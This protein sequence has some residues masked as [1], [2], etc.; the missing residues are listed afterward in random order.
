MN[1]DLDSWYK[2]IPT[3]RNQTARTLDSFK[4]NE[5]FEDDYFVACVDSLIDENK[6]V[7]IISN[8]NSE[9]NNE[10]YKKKKERADILYPINEWKRISDLYNDYDLFPPELHCDNFEQG[11]IGDCYFID[12]VALI[13]NYGLLT[14]LFPIKEKNPYGYY[15]VILFIN[16]WK[17]VIVDDYIPIKDGRPLGCTSKK[18]QKCFYFMLL[19]KA[20]AKVNKN[21]YNIYGGLSKNSLLVLTGFNAIFKNFINADINKIIEDIENGIRKQGYFY[22]ID[23]ENHAYS[24]LDIETYL[25]N[26]I[27]Y[28][29][30]KVRNPWGVTG[31][32]FLKKK[33]NDD[34]FNRLCDKFRNRRDIVEDE[35]VPRLGQIN[36][37]NDNGIFYI[38]KT[39]LFTFFE[40]YN[41]CYNMFGSSTIEFLL[42]I[43][44]ENLNRRYF[45]FELNATEE[46]LVQLNLTKYFF[47]DDGKMEFNSTKAYQYN[48]EMKPRYPNNDLNEN[49][50]KKLPKGKYLIEWHYTSNHVPEEILFWVHYIGNI[51]LDFKGMSQQSQIRN[52]F[53]CFNSNEVLIKEK[54]N[55]KLSEKLGESFYRK[56]K[57]IEFTQEYLGCNITADQEDRGYSLTYQENDDIAFSFIMN[58]EDIKNSKKLS[59][60]LDFPEYIFEGNQA[61][62]RRI[63]GEG[64]IYEINKKNNEEN[65]KLVF[66]GHINYNLFPQK[67][68]ENDQSDLIVRVLSR[69]F[70]LSQEIKEDELVCCSLMRREGYGDL[71]GRTKLDKIHPHALVKCITPN[72]LGWRCDRC[73]KSF[74]NREYSLYCTL[75]DFDYCNDNCTH[76]CCRDMTPHFSK[77]FQFK[78]L[79]HEHPLVKVKIHE[80]NNHL[81]CFSCL[82]QIPKEKRLYYCTKCDFRLCEKCQIAESRGRPWQFTTSWHEHPLT[83]CK[84]KGKKFTPFP[85]ID[86]DKD[87]IDILDDYAFYFQCN[88][89]GIE[90]SRK[91]DSFYCTACDFYICMKCY[92]N[93]YFYNGR[94]IENK[95]KVN[96]KNEK[97]FPVYCRCYLDNDNNLQIVNCNKCNRELNLNDWTYYCS[98][99]NS[100]F[101]RGC[102]QF[103]QV[104]F[105]NNI[106]IY[107]GSIDGNNLKNGYGITYK[108]NN[109][110]N[111][112]GNWDNGA[113]KLLRNINHFSDYS[114]IR[115][116][117]NEDI[118]CDICY[119]IC[120]SY[121]SGL[122]CRKNNLDIC[123]TCII[124]INS[125]LFKPLFNGY[126]VNIIR[127]SDFKKCDYCN[128]KKR[129][130]FFRIRKNNSNSKAY[131]LLCF[132]CFEVI[133]EIKNL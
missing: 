33:D 5:K 117:F 72:R 67:I 38:S 27:I 79:Q 19:E 7:Q 40:S 124:K 118:Q 8:F 6:Y 92:K 105:E 83:F 77:G 42:K 80:R 131:N 56:A 59:Q 46:S 107:D 76:K 98:N 87:I 86:E 1:K 10:D 78:T 73:D 95:V 112:S 66:T 82:K 53:H 91:K 2:S 17:R 104:I 68:Q 23:D 114:L 60:N 15:E 123:D 62:N 130:I 127:F 13:S 57:I 89:C 133:K 115:N 44:V 75:C 37:T 26:N 39:Y 120:D 34:Y 29:V 51:E 125:R 41:K 14:R 64:K 12:M 22:G 31:N 74:D 93:Y 128:I 43:N 28:K 32:N 113:F 3:F 96:M 116:Y 111:Y 63:L 109:E 84:T 70:K 54:N 47:N 97:V 106:L 122:S 9:P 65:F 132:N 94:E 4:P 88:H 35:L 45:L 20:W 61:K 18:Y 24:L 119:K 102:Y 36:N 30:L 50:I 21:Y 55:Y 52:N 48:I 69:R 101:C 100:I 90:Y 108:K 85:G 99:C 71:E 49:I 58:K 129:F 16:G 25:V 81:K 11:Q 103:H 121:D 126:Y 110:I